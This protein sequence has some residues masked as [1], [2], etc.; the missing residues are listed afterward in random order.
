[1]IEKSAPGSSTTVSRSKSSYLAWAGLMLVALV[2]G[3]NWVVM[4]SALDYA[5]PAVFAAMRISLAGVL[6]L[7]LLVVTGR[8]LRPPKWRLTILV[9]LFS[10]TGFTGLTFWALHLGAAGK[11]SV[12]VYTMPIWL[13]ILS[14]VF[15][16]E[17]VRGYQWLYVGLAIAGL[18]LVISPWSVGGTLVGNLIALGSGLSSAIGAVLAKTLCRDTR[19]DLLSLNAWQMLFGCV[20]L[21]IIAVF[22]ADSGPRWTGWF[23]VML[24][25][26]VVLASALAMMLWFYSLRHLSAGT[27]GLGR[28]IAPVVGVVAS[29]L[30]LGERPNGYE[31]AGI[32]MIMVGLTALAAHQLV[33]ERRTTRAGAS[34]ATLAQQAE[35]TAAGPAPAI[36][37]EQSQG[38]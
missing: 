38:D 2:H 30:Q 29:F 18:I 11:T 20:P 31:V 10:M 3:Y 34:P 35:G 1:M 33:G 6:L 25:Y 19:V 9:G 24:L 21:I 23:V 32:V 36:A 13:L 4:K 37:A 5:H 7:V 28:L 15:L 26:N 16:N 27:A 22:T 17:R 14:R 8:P 12:L